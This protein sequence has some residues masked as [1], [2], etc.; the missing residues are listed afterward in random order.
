[1]GEGALEF[2]I[3]HFNLFGFDGQ[4]WMLIVAGLV[5]AFVIFVWNTRD[6]F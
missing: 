2:L 1:M 6:R 3:G 5:A 4:N